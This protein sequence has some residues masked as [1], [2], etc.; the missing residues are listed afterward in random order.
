MSFYRQVLEF[1]FYSLKHPKVKL[2][3]GAAVFFLVLDLIL[4]CFFWLP[5]ALQNHRLQKGI[6]DHQKEVL[7]ISRAQAL[8]DRYEYISKRVNILESKWASPV[9]QSELIRSLD[10]LAA[11]EGLKV[12]SQDFDL[13]PSVGNGECFIQNITLIGNYRSLRKFL[14]DLEDLSTLTLVE[15]AR[16]ERVGDG[17]HVRANLVLTTYNKSSFGKRS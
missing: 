13:H 14:D 2:A 11:R 17:A 3:T 4:F 12:I 15:Q 16:L 5:V 1:F 8:A 7:E 10:R 6:E 9:S